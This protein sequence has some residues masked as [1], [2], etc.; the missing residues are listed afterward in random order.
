[1]KGQKG[2]KLKFI[3]TPEVPVLRGVCTFNLQQTL[4]VLVRRNADTMAGADAGMGVL[5]VSIW[6]SGGFKDRSSGA[7]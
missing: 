2:R 6:L 7:L 1:M 3:G 4:L 5:R